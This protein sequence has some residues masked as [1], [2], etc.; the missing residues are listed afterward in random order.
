MII[1]MPYSYQMPSFYGV[2][3]SVVV[4]FALM[5]IIEVIE[6]SLFDFGLFAAEWAA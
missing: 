1:T 4:S 3:D 6:V 2:G 5:V